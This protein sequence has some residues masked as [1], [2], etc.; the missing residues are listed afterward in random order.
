MKCVSSKLD[1]LL[2]HVEAES[3][4]FWLVELVL[5]AINSWKDVQCP[6]IKDYRVHANV[7][8]IVRAS[9]A[10]VSGK[11]SGENIFYENGRK[12]NDESKYDAAEIPIEIPAEIPV[13]AFPLVSTFISVYALE[14]SQF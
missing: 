9:E 5:R 3:N 2:C 11:I 12:Q 10:E 14:S 13:A 8:L 6:P 1:V 7:K 4:P